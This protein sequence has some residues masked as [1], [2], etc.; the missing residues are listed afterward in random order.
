MKEMDTAF[1]TSLKASLQE[2]EMIIFE[3]VENLLRKTGVDP[4]EVRSCT[5]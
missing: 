1:K 5:S 4:K 2:T 3:V